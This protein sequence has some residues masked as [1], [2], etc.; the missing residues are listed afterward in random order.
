MTQRQARLIIPINSIIKNWV[1][2]HY[3]M[4]PRFNLRLK[5][6][7][8]YYFPNFVAVWTDQKRHRGWQRRSDVPRRDRRW[9]AVDFDRRHDHDQRRRPLGKWRKPRPCCSAGEAFVEIK[10]AVPKNVCSTKI[11]RVSL[12]KYRNGTR[13]NQAYP[14]QEAML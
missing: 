4:S 7:R 2:G 3:G 9:L 8:S 1:L 6:R 10:M 12:R 13:S 14:K 5:A 11:A